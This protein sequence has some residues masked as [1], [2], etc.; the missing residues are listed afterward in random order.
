MTPAVKFRFDDFVLDVDAFELRQAGEL[1]AIEPLVFETLLLLVRNPGRMVSKDELIEKVWGG[2]F[3]SDSTVSTAIKMLRRLLGDT[4]KDQTYI[5]TVRGRGYAFVGDLDGE[6]ASTQPA[7]APSD[8]HDDSKANPVLALKVLRLNGALQDGD[9]FGFQMN[10]RAILNRIPL[11]RISARPFSDDNPSDATL[12]AEVALSQ[13]QDQ[14][15]GMQNATVTLVDLLDNT[16]V[17]ARTLQAN[18]ASANG[19]TLTNRIVAHLEPAIQKQMVRQLK[20]SVPSNR[21]RAYLMEAV[22]HLSTNGWNPRS[23]PRAKALLE[24]AVALDPELSLGH[25]YLALV[26]AFGWRVGAPPSDS[27]RDTAMQ[28]AQ[29]AMD[30]DAQ[31]SI[32][33]GLAGCAFCDIGKLERGAPILDRAIELDPQNGHA[34]TAKGAALMIEAD[35]VEASQYLRKGI[36][37]SPA[38]PRLSVWGALL[39]LCELQCGDVDAALEEARLAC[40]RD[41][42]NPLPKLAQS[43]ILVALDDMVKAKSAVAEL[44]RVHPEV[45]KVEVVRLSGRKLGDKIWALISDLQKKKPSIES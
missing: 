40:A 10:L 6:A 43:T 25:A 31:S 30:G 29:K 24:E 1:L 27:S 8:E 7:P 5:R 37:I 16:Q 34:L 21:P 45:E 32:V 41:D 33:L 4:G 26:H 9:A 19:E 15:L 44:L 20:S 12:L 22:S 28:A 17:W 11:L 18:G 35:F 14:D 38:D 42:R 23:F 3:V 39:A 2:R 13:G 36:D